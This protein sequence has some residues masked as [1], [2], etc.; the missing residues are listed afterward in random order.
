MLLGLV[1]SAAAAW[2]LSALLYSWAWWVGCLVPGALALSLLQSALQLEVTVTITSLGQG[3]VCCA[4]SGTRRSWSPAVTLA[5]V[6]L[7]PN[8]SEVTTL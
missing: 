7:W 3:R 4:R 1:T 6:S 5:L 8:I 2:L